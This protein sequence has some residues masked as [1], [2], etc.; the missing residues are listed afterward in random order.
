[1]RACRRLDRAVRMTPIL[2]RD[3]EGPER[4]VCSVVG[5]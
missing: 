1:M 5:P 4:L 2:G 3:R